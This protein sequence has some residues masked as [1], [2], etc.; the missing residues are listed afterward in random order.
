MALIEYPNIIPQRQRFYIESHSQIQESIFTRKKTVYFLAGS[1]WMARFNYTVINREE[2]EILLNFISQCRGQFNTFLIGDF[3]NEGAEIN[4]VSASISDSNTVFVETNLVLPNYVTV[5][6]RLKKIV[7]R[8]Y[9]QDYVDSDDYLPVNYIEP[10]SYDLKVEPPFSNF[11]VGAIDVARIN[12]S[13]KGVFRLVDDR[14]ASNFTF[15]NYTGSG[16]IICEEV[17]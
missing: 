12:F 4:V 15:G 17:I 9:Q 2:Y 14:Q 1:R 6:D 3:L 10:D 5:N 16:F 7:H 11:T 13:G 8:T